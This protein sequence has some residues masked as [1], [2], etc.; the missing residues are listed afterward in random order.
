M[1]DR[2]ALL[3]PL[4]LMM[5]LAGITYWINQIVQIDGPRKPLRHDPDYIITHF[6]VRRFDVNGILQHTLIADRMAHYPDDD[7]SVVTSP[8]LINHRQPVT[9]IFARQGLVGT[10]AKQIDFVDDVRVVRHGATEQT[11]ATVM[12]TRLLTVFPDDEIG[13]TLTPVTIT[14]GKN[15]IHGSSLDLNNKTGITVLHGRVTGT[16]YRNPSPSP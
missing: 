7:T 12:A 14:Q 11:L 16:L 15:I 5:L 1:R 8:H 13:H 2:A 6:N 4:V 3:G 10:Q 9:E